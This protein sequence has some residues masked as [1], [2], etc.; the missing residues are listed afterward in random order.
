[1]CS[2]SVIMARGNAEEQYTDFEAIITDR[3]HITGPL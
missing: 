2:R 1:M 3:G